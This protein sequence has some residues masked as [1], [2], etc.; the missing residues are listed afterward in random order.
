MK[1]AAQVWEEQMQQ[2]FDLCVDRQELV[3]LLDAPVAATNETPVQQRELQ[4]SCA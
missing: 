4:G 1:T 3:Q 2:I